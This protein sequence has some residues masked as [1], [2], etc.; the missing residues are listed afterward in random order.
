MAFLATRILFESD[1]FAMGHVVT[2]GTFEACLM[3]LSASMARVTY[4]TAPETLPKPGSIISSGCGRSQWNCGDEN[5]FSM[6]H[7]DD[8]R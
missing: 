8:T 7:D 5:D 3:L 4:L 6:L 1:R 2:F